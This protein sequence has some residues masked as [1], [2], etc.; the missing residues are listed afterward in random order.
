[1]IFQCFYS[2][3]T[4][5]VEKGRVPALNQNFK[6][7]SLFYSPNEPVWMWYRFAK[8]NIISSQSSIYPSCNTCYDSGTFCG[9]LIMQY[10]WFKGKIIIHHAKI[11]YVR[12]VLFCVI[13]PYSVIIRINIQIFVQLFWIRSKTEKV[14]LLKNVELI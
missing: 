6:M 10:D 11:I 2:V 13:F 3:L 14:T 4:T 7:F 5:V 12:I 1:M 8:E 9:Y